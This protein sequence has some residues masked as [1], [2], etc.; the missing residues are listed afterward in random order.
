MKPMLAL[1]ILLL[2]VSLTGCFTAGL[3]AAANLTEVN[4]EQANFEVVAPNASGEAEAGYLI[5]LSFS[6]G[7]AT[8]TIALIPVSGSGE[9][10][11]EALEDLWATFEAEH[12]PIGKRA[13]ALAN[14]RYDGTV[15]N[16]LVYTKVKTSIRADI[17]EFVE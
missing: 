11:K 3:F 17:I 12:G 2:P 5:G 10:Y 1:L 7:I 16:T 4:L 14:V 6:T 8:Q 9:L 15:L 13:L